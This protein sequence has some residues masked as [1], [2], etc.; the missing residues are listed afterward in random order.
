MK[1]KNATPRLGAKVQWVKPEV[2]SMRAGSAEISSVHAADGP[3][4][5]F[6]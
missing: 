1:N 2:R 5:N 4:P 6:S 3:N